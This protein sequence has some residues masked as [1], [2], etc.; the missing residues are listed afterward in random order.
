MASSR[1]PFVPG[2]M[3]T[4]LGNLTAVCRHPGFPGTNG[5]PDAQ[6]L[7]A[8]HHLWGW[9]MWSCLCRLA[10]KPGGVAC[11]VDPQ[12]PFNFG[13]GRQMPTA[14]GNLWPTTN[15]SST[16]QWLQ[17]TAPCSLF[18]CWEARVT[19][20]PAVISSFEALLPG[21]YLE[22]ARGVLFKDQYSYFYERG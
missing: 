10:S 13:V 11:V 9:Q 6:S 16:S 15:C 18:C 17:D 1:G 4:M 19:W 14:Q 22:C 8:A 3:L 21:A 5:Q 2:T 12:P 7:N 20:N